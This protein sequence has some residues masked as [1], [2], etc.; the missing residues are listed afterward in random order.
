MSGALDLDTLLD[1]PATRIIVCCGSGGV[2]KTTVS[3]A[4][5]V[6]A[7]DRG[8]HAVVL[9]ID[10]ARRLA[11]SMGLDALGNDPAPV[12]IGPAA[13]SL[14]A[15]TLD[16]TRTFDEIVMAHADPERAAQILANPIY[17][18]LSTSFA[19][20][21]EYMA[22]EKLAQLSERAADGDAWDLIIVDTPPSRSALDFLDAPQR[23][24]SFLDG[25]FIRLLM[26]PA[27]RTGRAGL[28]VLEAGAGIAGSILDKV[29]GAELLGDAR[30]FIGALEAVFG[31]FR[32]RA[33][34]TYQRLKEPGTAFVVVAAPE[35]DALREAA[36][37]VERLAEEGMPLAGLVVNRVTP[38]VAPWVN[39]E[40]A[41]AGRDRLDDDP[42]PDDAHVLARDLLALHA[43]QERRRL[44]E[45]RAVEVFTAAR[46]W[47]DQ[48]EIPALAEDVHDLAG[49]RRI[50]ELAAISSR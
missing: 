32:E 38:S 6:R 12:D 24:G 28:R 42:E 20:T 5:A 44:M 2:G 18:S 8:R 27:R 39:A 43:D 9:T 19:G 4:L 21:Q 25:P 49:L 36:F 34:A 15:M 17:R 35:Q 3:A 11:Q 31:D 16:M 23:L 46:P 37:F 26:A 30:T 1:D 45:S 14:Q 29:L 48:V 47:V 7:A 41:A 13:G 50:G 40:R 22:M 10:P 33:D